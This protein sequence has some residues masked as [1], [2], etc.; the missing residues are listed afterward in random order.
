MQ[1]SAHLT[2]FLEGETVLA[3]A[4]TSVRLKRVPQQ[5]RELYGEEY[6]SQYI[7]S[8]SGSFVDRSD[9]QSKPT[10]PLVSE[11]DSTT[12]SGYSS[13]SSNQS[14]LKSESTNGLNQRKSKF[15]DKSSSSKMSDPKKEELKEL[16]SIGKRR[17]FSTL[18]SSACAT[19]KSNGQVDLSN[20]NRVLH[21]L[22]EA[23]TSPSPKVR[24][25]VGTFQDRMLKTLSPMMPTVFV[26][27]YF[28][29]GEMAKVVPKHIK[30]KLD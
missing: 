25:F 17:S 2:L 13:L 5:T 28:T 9:Q 10:S 24:Y 11:S 19:L 7:N 6:F 15:G 30:E 22:V 21:A 20:M 1:K 23:V 27:H 8:V 16:E 26:D 14:T 12:S 18:S 29:S 3:D 4:E